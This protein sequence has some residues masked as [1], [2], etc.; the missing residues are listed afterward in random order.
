MRCLD[1][2]VMQFLILGLFVVFGANAI[3]GRRDLESDASKLG[4]PDSGSHG[5]GVAA[6]SELEFD[7][8]QYD[9]SI[10]DPAGQD[11]SERF[12]VLGSLSNHSSN[13]LEK[14]ALSRPLDFCPDD[15]VFIRSY[16]REEASPQAYVI[17]CAEEDEPSVYYRR[18]A[19]REICVRGIPKPNP[20]LP[21]GQLRPPTMKAYCV[22][23]EHFVRIGV[24]RAT[25]KTL[26]GT[27]AT[28]YKAP[29]GKTMAMEAVLTGLNI[30]ESMFASSLRMSAQTSDIS[31]NVQ[32]WRSQVGGTIVCTDCARIVIAPVPARTQRFVLS[33][34]LDAA[35]AGG[36]L[37]LSQIAI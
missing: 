22:G 11:H 13:N 31:N 32:T 14:R 23:T 20:P 17:I 18:C 27:I 2:L 3:A 30:S 33:V 7:D 24:N 8:I 29:E 1:L 34:V 28:Q 15:E 35:A 25:H 12:Q 19:A 37:F 9:I 26:P 10:K 21:T 6:W 4:S 16:C 5:K 36:L